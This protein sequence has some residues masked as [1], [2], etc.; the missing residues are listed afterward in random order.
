MV[1]IA[2]KNQNC[3]NDVMGEHLPMVFPPLFD[4]DNHDLLQPESVLYEDIAFS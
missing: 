2:G 3:S 1:S 4:I